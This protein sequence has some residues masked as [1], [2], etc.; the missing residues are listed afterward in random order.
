MRRT[1]T[2]KAP[3]KMRMV[4][5][6]RKACRT[7]PAHK[8]CKSFKA[9]PSNNNRCKWLDTTF[10]HFHAATAEI[11]QIGLALADVS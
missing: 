5:N 9:N 4:A 3:T 7:A 2:Y 8:N 1:D 11:R 10:I 6:E